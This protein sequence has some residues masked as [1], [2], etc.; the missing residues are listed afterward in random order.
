VA[1]VRA[2]VL[3]VTALVLCATAAPASAQHQNKFMSNQGLSAGNAK[4]SSVG[5]T[6]IFLIY[7]VANHTW[8]PSVA[9]GY[10]GYTSTPNSGG[11]FTAH[12]PTC[13]PHYQEWYPNGTSD[14]WFR[15]AAWNRNQ[16]TFD[17]F[18]YAWAI[19]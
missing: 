6:D 19:W 14:I 13:G 10:S 18:D 3:L 5:Y 17:D 4:S 7:G 11:H 12:S 15:G 16:S 2:N 8:C 9:Q 1:K